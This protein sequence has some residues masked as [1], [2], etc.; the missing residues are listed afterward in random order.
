MENSESITTIITNTI[1]TIFQN[2]FSSIDNNLYSILD[3]ITFIDESIL[4]D[5]N[6]HSIFG[7]SS[8]NGILL[9]AN[10]ILL[11][12]VLYYAIKLFLSYYT[13]NPVQRPYQFLLKLFLIGLFMNNSYFICEKILF[14]NS[15]LSLSIRNIGEEL[16]H[17]SI[18]FSSLID[19]F[20]SILSI[21]NTSFD[22]FSLDG[23]LKSLFSVGLFNL[24]F[25][26]S[27]RFIMI[28]VFILLFPFALL[29]ISL[30]SSIWFFKSWFRCFISLLF[31]QLLISFIL[32]I[33]FSLNL[34][35][36]LLSKCIYIGSIYSLIKSNSY[37]KDLIG[38]IS[39]DINLNLS[40]FK[41]NF[42][43]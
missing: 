36:D 22:I 11:G 24:I 28:K 4:N 25:S 2:L 26:Y 29:S 3:D 8:S 12:F 38:G 23:I 19:Q 7:K 6:F 40:N 35:F 39:T 43:M 31:M 9:I 20:N 41:N 5:E 42:H 37:I 27:L 17:K 16:F 1:N 14:F 32:L 13:S 33:I 15:T 21:E 34:N 18:C 10:S 30:D